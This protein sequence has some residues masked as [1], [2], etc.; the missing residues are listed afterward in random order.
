MDHD[1]PITE[2]KEEEC[3]RKGEAAGEPTIEEVLELVSFGR[4]DDGNLFIRNVYSDV[5][6]SV[7]RSVL[8][9]VYGDVKRNIN[10]SV[11]GKISRRNWR[12]DDA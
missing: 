11:Y 7:Y 12:F 4:D 8:A 5:H 2:A 3:E 6:G 10:G 1:D 9:S